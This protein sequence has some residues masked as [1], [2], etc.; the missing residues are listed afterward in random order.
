MSD[1]IADDAKKGKFS[2][3]D[4]VM[5]IMVVGVIMTI[6]IPVQQTKSHET[7]VKNSLQDMARIINANEKFK[8]NDLFEE[9]APS[10]NYLKLEGLDQSIFTYTLTDTTVVA[11][12]S[13]LAKYD[14][15]YYYDLREKKFR[16]SE[17]S[18]DI[19]L[20][21]WMP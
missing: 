19:I 18:E 13:K 16:V 6:V 21:P 1:R 2:I 17:D 10:L 14:K 20:A 3:I 12:S 15:S 8:L 9:Y 11:T 5:I 4:L 7:Y